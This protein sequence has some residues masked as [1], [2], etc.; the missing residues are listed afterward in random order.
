MVRK[1]NGREVDYIYFGGRQTKRET[2]ALVYVFT[3]F[4]IRYTYIQ[5]YF[6]ILFFYIFI[7]ARFFLF[8]L[9]ERTI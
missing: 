3:F 9:W 7:Y 2:H 4:T 8:F 5:T 1:I 6:R